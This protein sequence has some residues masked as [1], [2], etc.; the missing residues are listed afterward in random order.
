MVKIGI[1]GLGFM[2]KMHYGC[3][4]SLD[5][6]KIIAICDIDENRFK[7]TGETAG[8]IAGAEG[9]LDLSDKT[10]YTD[11]DE[12]VE[13][14]D[15]DGISICLPT[16]LHPEYTKKAL[17]AG[18]NVLCEK[19]MAL[20]TELCE[21]MVAAANDAGK[22]LQIGQCIRFW[23]E[24]VKLKEMIESKEYGELKVLT[25]QR[26]ALTPTTGWQNWYLD[27]NKSG[28]AALDLHIH[29][30]DFVQYVFGMPK[31]VVTTGMT[32]PTGDYDH[33]VTQYRYDDDKV[34]TAE[35]G[36]MMQ[37]SWGFEMSF[38]AVFEKATVSF[39]V[40][41]DP[42]FRVCPADGDQFTPDVLPGTG[43]SQEIA[44][45][46]NAIAGEDVPEI[47]TSQASKESVRLVLAE[48][49][50]AKTGSKVEL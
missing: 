6:A 26:L 36:W 25:F 33:M 24:Y 35:G 18:L 17:K 34:I 13:K 14:E 22:R 2:G 3:Y 8:N 15:L 28:G 7:N 5:N 20:S 16:Y 46:V 31:A 23:P 37:A 32:G 11:F 38:N 19:P 41:K 40:T 10:L 47:T 45:F 42:M 49:E 44:H 43:Y 39:D 9:E 30:S 21:E 1:V 50:S 4:S 27:G 48:K 12:M 29:D